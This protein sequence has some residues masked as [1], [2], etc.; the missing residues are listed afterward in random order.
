[1]RALKARG[2]GDH[3]RLAPP[4]RGVR[5]L[6]PHRRHARRPHP[7]ATIARATYSRQTIV[8]EMVGDAADARSARRASDARRRSRSRSRASASSMPRR[9]AA[10]RPASISTSARARSSACSACSAPA[11]SRRRSPSTAPG[12]GRCEGEIL[13]DGAA[14][15]IGRPDACG[16][17]RPRADGAGSP[18]LPDRRAVGRRQYR[19]RQPRPKHRAHG[20][21]DVA[22]G[23]RRALDQVDALEHQGRVDRRRG[24]ARCRAATSRRCRS[25]AGWPPRRAS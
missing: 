1:M 14:V 24:A 12:P 19:H 20:V 16:G 17:A 11:A 25:R 6:R 10:G 5:H 8:A 2:R 4:G 22:A 7:R 23:R 3:L 9:P 18:R 13:V 15:A 21:L